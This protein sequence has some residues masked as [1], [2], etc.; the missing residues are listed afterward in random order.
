[1]G[2]FTNEDIKKG[3]VVWELDHKLDLRLLFSELQ[4]LPEPV[5]EYLHV[6]GY[7]EMFEGEK[8]IVLCGDHSKHMNHAANPNLLG[9]GGK[10]NSDVAKR[11]IKAG[12]ELT[13]DYYEFDLDAVQKLG[14]A[15]E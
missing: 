11:D 2:C 9:I 5:Q 1:L 10:L 8:T 13:C 4:H 14:A 15:E 12:E 7:A 6:Y 3:Q